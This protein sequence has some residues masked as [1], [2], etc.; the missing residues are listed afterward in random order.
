MSEMLNDL[1]YPSGTSLHKMVVGQSGS[2]KSFFL[3]ATAKAFMKQNKNPNMRLIYFS[4][5]NEG[6]TDLLQKKQKPVNDVEGMMKQ[7]ADNRTVVF[8][9]E[10]TGLA[11]TMDDVINALFDIKDENPDFRATLIVDDCQVFLSARKQ[12]SDAFN[13]SH[14][15]QRC[16]GSKQ[17]KGS[18]LTQNRM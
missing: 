3:E 16:I 4:P 9:P 12:A 17:T 8:Y 13:R 11:D 15:R 14:C 2:G 1:F 18:G 6:F 7:L 10:I 5:K